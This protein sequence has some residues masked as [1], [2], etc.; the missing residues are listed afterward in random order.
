MEEEQPM[1]KGHPKEFEAFAQRPYGRT[2]LSDLIKQA[3]QTL[4]RSREIIEHARQV[5]NRANE[6][7]AARVRRAGPESKVPHIQSL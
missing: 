6:V 5:K 3:N 4:K 7:R 2:E 1:D